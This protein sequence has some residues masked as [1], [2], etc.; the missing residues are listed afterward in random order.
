MYY[1]KVV[2]NVLLYRQIESLASI[3]V[4]RL[5]QLLGFRQSLPRQQL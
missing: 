3:T 2:G 1:C 5:P 4:A